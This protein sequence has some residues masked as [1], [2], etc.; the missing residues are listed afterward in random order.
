LRFWRP[1]AKPSLQPLLKFA[2][3]HPVSTAPF[4][5]GFDQS[6]VDFFITNL[7]ER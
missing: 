5:R 6:L 1:A 2:R 7:R 3:T 4:H